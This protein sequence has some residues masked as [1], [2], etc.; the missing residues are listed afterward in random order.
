M[1]N[2]RLLQL[3][4]LII[5]AGCATQ[6]NKVAND[7]PDL[8]C[9][10]VETTGSMILKS[11]CTTRAQQAAQQAQLSDLRQ[12]VEAKAGADTRPTAPSEQ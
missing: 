6:P 11:T 3:S 10:R 8:Q 7:G 2:A 4:I 5:V 12:V 1:P 9:R